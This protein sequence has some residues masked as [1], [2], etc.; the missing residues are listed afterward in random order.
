MTGG[1]IAGSVVPQD[2][3]W[4]IPMNGSWHFNGGQ[5]MGFG[6]RGEGDWQ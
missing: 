3:S 4:Y 1:D 2:A 6:G 5:D